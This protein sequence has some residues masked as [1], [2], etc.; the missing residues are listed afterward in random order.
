MS[1]GSGLLRGFAAIGR[2]L[3]AIRKVLH[4]IFLFAAL[5][6]VLVLL[7]PRLHEV[8][9]QAALVLDPQGTIV[10]QLS[11]DPFQQAL[12]R[13]RGQQVGQVLLRDLIDAIRTAKD[14]DRIKALVLELDGLQ[15][16]GLSKLQALGK[17]IASF[18]QS[19]KRVIAVGDNFDRDRYYLAA[20]ADDVYMNPAG[21]V[22]I[23]GYGRY[24]PY[25]KSAIDKLYIDY[26]VWKVGKYKSFVEPITRNDMSPADRE[27]STYYLDG[28]WSAYQQD[29]TAARQLPGDSLQRYADQAA[30]L[31]KAAGGD[32]G[33]EA[34]DYGLV[35]ELLTR[36][37]ARARLA[38]LVGRDGEGGDDFAQV[39]YKDYLA[40][41]RERRL[42][43]RERNKV[44]VIVAS[45]E[46]LDGAQPSGSV[47]GDS[48]VRL[49]RRATRDKDVKALVL[50]VDSP[51]GSAFASGLIL[52][53]LQVFQKTGRP[54]VVSMSSVAASGGYWISM[55][56]DQIWASPTTLTGSIGVGAT[57]PTFQDTL[58]HLGV[59]VDGIGTT[60]LSGAY[61]TTRALGDNIKAI[62]DS[63]IHHTYDQFVSKVAMNRGMSVDAVEKVAGGRV[64]TGKQAQARGLVDKLGTFD[65]AV[66]AAAQLAGLKEGRYRVSYIAPRL[67]FAERVALRLA[68][69]AAPVSDAIGLQAPRLPKA[70][71]DVLDAASGPLAILKRLNDPHGI[72]AYCFCDVK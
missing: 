35:D 54:L 24:L 31:L 71:R 45:G 13:A 41:T 17:E 33:K 19:G 22:L 38:D 57:L 20:Q 65:D 28:L 23:E 69:A 29:V 58:A 26:N 25:Y 40:A 42:P 51:G 64:W 62:I 7:L 10:E 8:P 56:G 63:S 5:I 43:S 67:S 6:A 66:D 16:A 11:G 2:A 68:G 72:Y 36:D 47:G 37:Q 21:S 27:A 34:V 49:I 61:Q 53:A 59:H 60:K 44:G 4:F 14:D 18:K 1:I 46:I 50:R 39:D 12:A 9:N 3:D 48:M 70:L 55:S 32:T 52:R 15:G 30:D